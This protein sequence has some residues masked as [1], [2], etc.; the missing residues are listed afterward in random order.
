MLKN[1]KLGRWPS[2]AGKLTIFEHKRAEI[3]VEDATGKSVYGS[4][5]FE[6]GDWFGVV[7]FF[8]DLLPSWNFIFSK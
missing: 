6:L 5:G 3:S 7:L 8:H 4:I 1:R 2:I